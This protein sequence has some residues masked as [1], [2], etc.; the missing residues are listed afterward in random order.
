MFI[1]KIYIINDLDN[2]ILLFCLLNYDMWEE[3]SIMK[4]ISSVLSQM[5][6]LMIISAVTINASSLDDMVD[7]ETDKLIQQETVSENSEY[8]KLEADDNLLETEGTITIGSG[9]G[10]VSK[11]TSSTSNKYSGAWQYWS[12]GASKYSGM[13]SSGCRVTAFAKLLREAGYGIGN[14]DDFLIWGVN[15]GFFKSTSNVTEMGTFGGAILRYVSDNGGSSSLIATNTLTGNTKTDKANIM[16]YIRQGYYVVLSCSA[17]TAYI[18]REASLNNGTPVILDS[19]S[20]WSTNPASVHTYTGKYDSMSGVTFEKYRVY[21]ISRQTVQKDTSP[22]QIKDVQVVDVTNSGYTVKCTVTDNVGIGKVQF[23]TWTDKNGQDDIAWKEG[24]QFGTNTSQNVTFKVNTS[25]HNNEGDWYN[26]HIYA[27]DTSGNSTNTGVRVFIDK[28]PPQITNVRVT[29]IDRNGYTVSC[30]VTDNTGVNRVQFPS[31]TSY[32][33]Q[34]DIIQE[35]WTNTAASGGRNGDTYTYRVNRDSH[36]D[37]EL[38]NYIT[39]IYA[40]DNY[41][42]QS[43]VS[44]VFV[45]CVLG[46]KVDLGQNLLVRI[47]NVG[48]GTYLT[49]GQENVYGEAFK[50]NN[51][52]QK[53]NMIRL[54]DGSYCIVAEKYS[55]LYGSATKAVSLEKN[56]NGQVVGVTGGKVLDVLGAA[57]ANGT[58]VQVY[59]SNNT[60][61]QK[62]NIYK[63]SQGYY[64]IPECSI[65]QAL[66]MDAGTKNLQTHRCWDG[67][68]QFFY[69]ELYE[70]DKKNN[71]SGNENKADKNNTSINQNNSSKNNTAGNENKTNNNQ[72]S[73][74]ETKNNTTEA[75]TFISRMYTVALGRTA[76]QSG[77]N[78][79]TQK[80]SDKEIDGAGIAN[81]FI[82]SAEFKNRNLNNNDY[83][84]VLY[85]TFFDREADAVGKSYWMDKL[86]KG[87]SRTEILSGF[88]NSQEFSGLCDRFGI[89]RGTMQTNGTSIYRPGVRSYVL[90]MYTKALNRDGETVGVEDWTNRINTRVMS[91]EAVAKSFF[92]SQEFINRNLNNADYVETLY[93]TFMD[94]AS[95][96]KGKQYW[97]DKLNGGMSRQQVLEG[98]SRSEEFSKIMKRYGL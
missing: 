53:W 87:I 27:W 43:V 67:T 12:Q 73:I 6:I 2:R 46:D 55:E 7:Y 96:V 76:E 4:K 29:D 59:D 83:L 42:N 44:N 21:S 85:R 70:Q 75:S 11:N 39:H 89:A 9:V 81:G 69:I 41:G 34:D 35:W 47:K 51:P 36:N 79:W 20:S 26:T 38:F 18:G 22:P 32:N 68:P 3:I 74:N 72:Q 56:K 94:R 30:T 62:W 28:I 24:N 97:I 16:N 13:R 8:T 50:K 64:L 60:L 25:E 17:H 65:N 78:S 98:F 58:N 54:D 77:L 66:D 93:Q 31:W 80:L 61:A 88:V 1:K 49:Y 23:P 5:G 48:T 92:S 91:P 84:D 82:N 95:D 37:G 19:W 57:N 45:N 90:R 52:D 14:P 33:D 15:K 71:S 40:Y 63:A 10:K 86:Q